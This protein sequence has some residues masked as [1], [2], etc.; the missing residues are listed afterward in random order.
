MNLKDRDQFILL[1]KKYFREAELPLAGY[2][3]P[4]DGGVKIV[5]KPSGHSC[6]IGQLMAV[7]K[8]QS[9]CFR[10]DSVNCGGGKRY[11][12]FTDQINE[13]FACFL[14]NGE[15]GGFCERYKQSPELVE[16]L[17]EQI[18]RL[19]LAGENLIF[20]RWDKLEEQ[21]EPQFVVF[22]VTPDV[23]AGLFTLARFDNNEPDAVFII[24]TGNIWKK[25]TGQ[26]SGCSIRL[27]GNVL[28]PIY[29]LFLYLST[30]FG[31]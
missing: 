1:W 21:D 25:E 2:Y 18:P 19:P 20:K 3:S 13:R 28:K 17:I 24:R 9:L 23:L 11:L 12:G 4:S 22:F 31:N 14:S 26:L 27:P 29:F 16:R 5:P 8:G 30:G 7:R 6:L 10:P 15:D